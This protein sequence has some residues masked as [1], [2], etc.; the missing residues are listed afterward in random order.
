MNFQR[1]VVRKW[2]TGQEPSLAHRGMIFDGPASEKLARNYIAHGYYA[3]RVEVTSA[4]R[5]GQTF[6]DS[7]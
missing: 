6:Y 4:T 3:E 5:D 2:K 7:F 1:Y